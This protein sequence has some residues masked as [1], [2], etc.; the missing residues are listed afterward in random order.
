MQQITKEEEARFNELCLMAM[1]FARKNDVHMLENMIKAGLNPNLKD[2]KGNTLLMIATYN[3]NLETSKML[4]ENGALVDEKND[5]GQTPLAGVC[6]KGFLNIVKLL[7]GHGANID[8]NCGMGMTPYSFSVMFG[9]K[10]VTD[11]LLENSQNKSVL[12]K[13]SSKVLGILK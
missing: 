7:V 13:M 4:L 1:D 5:R 12:K 9:R 10:K 11:Y 6:F 8:E 3:G 2:H